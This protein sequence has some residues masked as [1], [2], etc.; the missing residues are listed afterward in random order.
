MSLCCPLVFILGSYT[1]WGAERW[2]FILFSHHSC[3]AFHCNHHHTPPWL[4]H[5]SFSSFTVKTYHILYFYAK[6]T[7]SS[8][9]RRAYLQLLCLFQSKAHRSIKGQN[10]EKSHIHLHDERIGQHRLPDHP[11]PL[12]SHRSSEW[13][14]RAQGG[15][16]VTCAANTAEQSSVLIVTKILT[17]DSEFWEK[18]HHSECKT[19]HSGFNLGIKVKV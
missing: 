9:Q 15:M 10:K 7:A 18:S 3:S 1:W 12:W 11:H 6:F 17:V 13:W 16:S 2:Y 8:S 5:Q 4:S 19:Q 14:W